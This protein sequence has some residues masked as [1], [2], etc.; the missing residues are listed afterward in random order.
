MT[1]G[2]VLYSM[3]QR[4]SD[5]HKNQSLK[6]TP[7]TR[8]NKECPIKGPFIFI[9][10]GVGGRWDLKGSSCRIWWLPLVFGRLFALGSESNDDG[11]GDGDGDGDSNE[12][13]KKAIGLDKKNNNFIC[14]SCLFVHFFTVTVQLW[15]KMTWTF[16]I[17][18]FMEDGNTWQ[19]FSLSFSELRN[20]PLEFNANF[21]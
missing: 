16:L 12:N 13:G 2:S 11:D 17:S 6:E 14:T 1:E 20:S 8:G 10:W 21:G 9:G 3:A 18:R 4:W 19:R 7:R 15:P 5:E